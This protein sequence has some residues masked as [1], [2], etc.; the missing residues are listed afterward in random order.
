MALK[1]RLI[2]VGKVLVLIVA[3]VAT[4]LLFAATAMRVALRVREVP[5]PDLRSRSVADATATLSALGLTLNVD[6]AQR[7]DPAIGPGRIAAQDPPAGV[8]TRRQRSIK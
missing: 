3:L 7:L 2:G 5:V 6:E 8:T 1:A 4:Y